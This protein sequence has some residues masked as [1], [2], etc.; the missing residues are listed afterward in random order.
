MPPSLVDRTRS[1]ISRAPTLLALC[2]VG[3]L[4]AC[5]SFEVSTTGPGQDAPTLTFVVEVPEGQVSPS[6][7]VPVSIR[8]GDASG[9]TLNLSRVRLA[10]DQ[11]EFGRTSGD[12]VDSGG[13]ND[14][15]ACAE[16]AVQPT[17][18]NVPVDQQSQQ[19]TNP[20]P[21]EAGT[22]DRLEMDLHIVAQSETNLIIS[23]GFAA[24]TSVQVRGTFNGRQLENADFSPEGELSLDLP[25]PLT[26]AA[27]ED[28][29]IV[30]T[31]DVG[32][33]FRTAG[34]ELLDPD[35]AAADQQLRQQV[36]QNVIDSFSARSAQ[37]P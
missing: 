14:G 1:A 17:A 31:V 22:Y 19:L 35:V 33:W 30:L 20:L 32:S 6:V 16:A 23:Q 37:N 11:V 5:S 36:E 34:G 15:D 7:D 10:V 3:A 12:C 9:D 4:A 25:Q 2:A 27:Q 18:L 29:S 8:V 26:L 21:V 13:A 28:A 24:G